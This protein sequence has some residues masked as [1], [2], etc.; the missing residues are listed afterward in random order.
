MNQIN[1][2]GKNKTH[3]ISILDCQFRIIKV[4]FFQ[5]IGENTISAFSVLFQKNGKKNILRLAHVTFQHQWR[6]RSKYW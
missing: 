3:V 6:R 1:L 2:S 5:M 4:L